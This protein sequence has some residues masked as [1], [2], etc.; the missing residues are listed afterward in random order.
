MPPTQVRNPRA[1]AQ[2]GDAHLLADI[3]HKGNSRRL[4]SWLAVLCLCLGGCLVA[5]GGDDESGSSNGGSGAQG[6]SGG[7]G[8]S[9]GASG[10]GGT[11][12]SVGLLDG[13]CDPL[14]PEYCTFPFPSNVWLR[15][16]PTTPTGKRVNFKSAS[17]PKSRSGTETTV[18]SLNLSDG[19]SA[20]TALM[21]YLPGATT[22]GLPTPLDIER[23]LTLDSPTLLVDA[24]TGELVPHFS[25]LDVGAKAPEDQAFMIRP[26]VRLK[27]GARYLVAIRH[28]VD[29]A[30][31]PVPPS[32]A[33]QALRDGTASD[34]GSV[35]LRR[36]LYADVFE[37]LTSAGV[38]VKDLQ[39][40]WDFTTASA[41]NNTAR[42]LHMRDAALAE[43]G[44]QG[45]SYTIDDAQTDVNED[46]AIRVEGKIQVPL[47]L[48]KPE[49]GGVMQLD[50]SG[51]PQKTG[52]AEYPFVLIVPKSATVD[53]PATVMWYGHG[54][55]GERYEAESFGDLAN[56]YNYAIVATDWSGMASDDVD[57][58]VGII[59]G[60]DIGQFRSVPD[61]LQ[62]GFLNA[63]LATRMAGNGFSQDP[64]VMQNGKSLI[65]S[66]EKVYFGGSQGGIFGAVYMAL[67][68]DVT[69]G[70]L[71][72]PGQSYNLLLQR[73]VNFDSFIAL[74]RVTYPSQLDI[75]M[76]LALVQM[77]WDRAEPNGYSHRATTN[78]LP[79][80]PEHQALL[81]VSIGDHQ[82][83]TLGAHIM[84]RAMGAKNLAPV[85]RSVFGLEE[86]T[87][88]FT[89]SGII[90]YDFGLPPEPITNEPMRE[91]ED[92]HPRIREVPSAGETLNNFLRTGVV[93]ATC[94]PCGLTQ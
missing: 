65:K 51:L 73:S 49:A 31:S 81:L 69:R 2:R 14:V 15:D 22:T 8:G 72:V 54:L 48:D 58:I 79:N 64:L 29:S 10:S 43:V 80:T 19:F 35:E 23:S 75:Q 91:G 60:G 67:S 44:S 53:D 24:E 90:E 59:T 11:A 13:D 57:N 68:T 78:P 7:A 4:A 32:P 55:L 33:F 74:M 62:Q 50:A 20:G 89:G 45:P 63:L 1:L 83:S 6:G 82:V 86:A 61:R 85:N 52:D 93:D 41:E 27:D 70:V 16:D 42:M 26:A 37:R 88:P 25:E 47:F 40:A 38:D 84:A 9:A 12:G 94:G 28:V 34:D 17:L 71:A 39:L 92:P 5:C 76:A 66:D 77:E 18:D 30:G 56:Q 46:I 3:F 36:E 87:G 21:A